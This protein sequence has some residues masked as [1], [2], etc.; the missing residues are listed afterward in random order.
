[1]AHDILILGS[2]PSGISTALHLVQLA[3]QLTSRILILEKAHHPRHK[4]CAGALV[5]D[6]EV[7]L[8]GLGLD[9]S[10]IPHVDVPTAHFDFDGQGLALSMPKAHTLRI[11][12]RNEFDAW[13]VQNARDQGIQI[14]E[15]ITVINVCPQDEEVR[16]ET[17]SGIFTGKL[18]VGADGSNGV[19]RRSVLPDRSVQTARVLEVITP[20]NM[21]RPADHAYF[22][23]LPVPAGIAGYTWE[24]PTQIDG[25]RM[26]SWGIYDT[27][28]LAGMDRQPLRAALS[29]AMALHGLDLN[30]YQIEGFPIRWFSPFHQFSVARVLLVGDAAGA[31]GI[32]GEGISMAL[33]YGFVAARAVRDALEQN[34]FSFKDYRRRILLSPLGQI[35]TIRST[36]TQIFYRIHGAWFQKFFWRTFKPIVAL[37]AWVLVINWAKRMK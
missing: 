13:L 29:D 2:G 6:A 26:S 5:T 14:R 12:R 37:I 25:Q 33:G 11:I 15:G 30:H 20:P 31:D 17:D 18:V 10:E 8:R 1:M 23:F 19:T 24:F 7:I 28:L 32:L 27:N 4:L 9:A 36:L 34:E 16:V 21:H 22:D 3:P 35:L